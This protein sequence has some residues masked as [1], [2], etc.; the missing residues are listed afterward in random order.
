M[1]FDDVLRTLRV[2]SILPREIADLFPLPDV[3]AD[4]ATFI[5]SKIEQAF[6]RADRLEAEAARA[7]GEA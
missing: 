2:R 7:D 5:V 6:A 4:V 1:T 3:S